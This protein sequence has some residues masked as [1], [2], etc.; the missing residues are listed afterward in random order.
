MKLE[1]VPTCIDCNTIVYRCLDCH[2]KMNIN[3][4]MSELIETIEKLEA[5]KQK[6]IIKDFIKVVRRLNNE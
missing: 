1:K 3:G 5:I 2:E 4:L 6:E